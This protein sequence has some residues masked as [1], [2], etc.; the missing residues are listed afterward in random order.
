MS[1]S[2]GVLFAYQ[3][4]YYLY[5]APS[6]PQEVQVTAVGSSLVIIS[7]FPP[8]S[9]NGVLTSYT[10][11]VLIGATGQVFNRTTITLGPDQQQALQTVS[12][13]GLD[14]ENVEYRVEVSASTSIG[15]GPSSEHILVGTPVTPPDATPPGT[16]PPDTTLVSTE[17]ESTT[18]IVDDELTTLSPTSLGLATSMSSLATPSPTLVAT[19]PVVRDDVYYVVRIVPPVA[20]T[21]L[22]VVMVLA[23]ILCCLH[24]RLVKK[25]KKGLYQ[26]PGSENEYR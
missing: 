13:A 24:R 7:W 2:W 11:L 20:G 22:L 12:V 8:D 25:K 15:S 17:G 21:F 16:T 9:P 23:I 19:V 3:C 18:E 10:L 1:S 4:K 14:L 6:A 26:F 5:S